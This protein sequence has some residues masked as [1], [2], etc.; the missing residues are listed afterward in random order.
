MTVIGALSSD[1]VYSLWFCVNICP[2]V[3]IYF[4]FSVV[5]ILAEKN[6][7]INIIINSFV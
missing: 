7:S 2:S 1:S 3:I 5:C 4:I 6:V